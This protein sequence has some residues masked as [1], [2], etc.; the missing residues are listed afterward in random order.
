MATPQILPNYRSVDF[1][2]MD[3]VT[4]HTKHHIRLRSMSV[5]QEEALK[6]SPVAASKLVNMLNHVVYDCVVEREDPF[7]TF[8]GFEHALSITDR[9]AV[10]FTLLLVSYG[11][12]QEFASTCPTCGKNFESKAKLTENAEIKCYDGKERLLQKKVTVELPIS[13]YKATLILPTLSDER[14]FSMSRGVSAEVLRKANDYIIVKDMQIP[15]EAT[16]NAE[17]EVKERYIT[18]DNTFEIYSM[19]SKLPA[20]DRKFIQ[21][22]WTTNFGEYGVTVRIPTVCPHCTAQADISV[23]LLTE[24][25]RLSQ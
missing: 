25:F 9:E 7:N 12:E 19:M 4:P 15:T 5:A 2:V 1:P 8:E 14:V 10:L 22:E 18:I 6:A 21:K 23:N 3:M 13:K 20:R 24:L 11:D 17:G 16:P